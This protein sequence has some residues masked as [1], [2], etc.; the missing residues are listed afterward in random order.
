MSFSNEIEKKRYNQRRY[1]LH[2]RCKKKGIKVLARRR[3]V[4]IYNEDI[5][6]YLRNK[7]LIELINRFNYKTEK[8]R[9][10]RI[11]FHEV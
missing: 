8:N 2:W 3:V 6:P 7:H 1:Y 10:Y 11:Q 5:E 9:Q 4:L